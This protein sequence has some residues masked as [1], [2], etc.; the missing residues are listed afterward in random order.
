MG[1]GQVQRATAGQH[2]RRSQLRGAP[3]DQQCVTPA[4]RQ[5]PFR[6]VEEPAVVG[7]IARVTHRHF[8]LVDQHRVD[9]PSRIHI[10][11][12]RAVEQ[13][14]HASP[15]VDQRAGI[16][17]QRR[18]HVRAVAGADHRQVDRP[19][20]GESL[21]HGQLRHGA[22]ALAADGRRRAGEMAERAIDGADPILHGQRS[23]VDQGHVDDIPAQRQH[24]PVG[25]RAGSLHGDCA[26]EGECGCVGDQGQVADQFEGVS[27]GQVDG[28]RTQPAGIRTQSGDSLVDG[29]HV[30]VSHVQLAAGAGEGA[31]SVV[32]G[33]RIA[34]AE[35]ALV[36][37]LG[38]EN[39]IT[40]QGGGEAVQG[41][42]GSS[43]CV[44]QGAVGHDQLGGDVV[45]GARA[46]H[47]QVDGA[48]VDES[49]GHGQSSDGPAAQ[50][51]HP[52]RRTGRVA[53]SAVDGAEAFLFEQTPVD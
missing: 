52:Q 33:G 15:A 41:P 51:L 19:L 44:D 50:S 30:S 11:R 22:V 6:A 29:Q 27:A 49:V 25:Q 5:R 35:G 18:R 40:S 14:D 10:R 31:S 7:H 1:A 46:D 53:E 13:T 3:V 4:D 36:V 26:A 23:L 28:A 16:H 34:D 43:C 21:R 47:G 39:A 38:S 37:Q 2:R 9:Q 24:R 42:D 17:L 32:E 20:V 48:L 12:R 8:S 45:V